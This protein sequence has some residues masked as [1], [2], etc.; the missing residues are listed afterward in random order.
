MV[1]L[2]KDLG[3]FIQD[4]DGELYRSSEWNGSKTANGIAIKTEKHS[5]VMA[6][7]DASTN[8]EVWASG[9]VLIDG[10][11]TTTDIN[12]AS[13]DYDGS[14]NT[15]AITQHLYT[16]AATQCAAFTFPN[17]KKGYLGAAGEHLIVLNN[18]SEIKN[19]LNKCGG[20]NLNIDYPYWTSTQYDKNNK[21]KM[22][23]GNYELSASV[24]T[25]TCFVRAFASIQ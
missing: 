4:V 5:F 20:A 3:I 9:S 25:L 11:T 18:L 16:G 14:N 12:E 6:L 15:S 1:Y 21:W 8:R 13:N 7:Q 2:N 24:L 19:L 23:Y 17:G 22:D 10:I